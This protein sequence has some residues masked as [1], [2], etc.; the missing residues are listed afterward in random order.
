MD[1]FKCPFNQT[2]RSELFGCEHAL[3]VTR[4]DGPD[5][6]CSSR[7]AQSQCSAVFQAMK[8]SALAALGVADDPQQM[9]HSVLVKVQFGGLLGLQHSLHMAPSETDRVENINALVG[10]A[11]SHFGSVAEI[12]YADLSA[13]I[14]AFQVKR[15]RK[16]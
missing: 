4:R 16:R 12:P 9:A 15:R 2:L 7:Q 14:T 3:T 10:Q 13:A 8:Q 5:V 11:V 1:E 6:N